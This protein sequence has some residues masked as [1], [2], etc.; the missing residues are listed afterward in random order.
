MK[1][2]GCFVNR[3]EARKN[4]A[5]AVHYEG[6]L[7]VLYDHLKYGKGY[8]NANQIRIYYFWDEVRKRHVVG[9]M[10]SHLKNNLTS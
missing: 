6:S 3:D 5:Y 7:H 4:S 2:S 9:K 8:D 10:P 1:D